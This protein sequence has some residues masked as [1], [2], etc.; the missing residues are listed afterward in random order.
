MTKKSLEKIYMFAG[1]EGAMAY[2]ADE[3][4][5]NLPPDHGPWRF[6]REVSTDGPTFRAGADKAALAEVEKNGF[7]VAIFSI[8]LGDLS[9]D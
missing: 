9:S 6:R 3:T 8:D 7:A 4:G 2:S 5:S 1:T